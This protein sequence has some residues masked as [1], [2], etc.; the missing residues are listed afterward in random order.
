VE[1]A[2]GES[3]TGRRQVWAGGEAAHS[4]GR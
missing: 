3:L 2:P 4:S 1:V